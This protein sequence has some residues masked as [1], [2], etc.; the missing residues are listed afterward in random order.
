MPQGIVL[1]TEAAR[2][3]S[4][5]ASWV[6]RSSIVTSTYVFRYTEVKRGPL[7]SGRSSIQFTPFASTA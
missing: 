7:P 4:G 1:V 6:Y 3:A 5:V 2:S